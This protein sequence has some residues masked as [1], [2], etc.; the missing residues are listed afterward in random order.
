MVAVMALR[1]FGKRRDFRFQEQALC[2]TSM[3]CK[4]KETWDVQGWNGGTS[5]HN[6]E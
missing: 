4:D 3:R 5:F 2:I 1:I 6:E